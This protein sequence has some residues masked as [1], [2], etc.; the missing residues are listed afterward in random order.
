MDHLPETVGLM[1]AATAEQSERGSRFNK[2]KAPLEL[3][4]ADAEIEE[5]Y[6]W[7][8]GQEKYGTGNWEKGLPVSEVIGCLLRHANAIKRGEDIDPE[9]GRHHAAHI[10]CNAA[11]LIR[12][13]GTQF[14]DR[15]K[16]TKA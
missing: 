16:K 12:F 7:G 4:P 11:M 3:I 6:V 5:A 13:T 15:T 8:A 14:D 2:G 9:T 10:R 1:K